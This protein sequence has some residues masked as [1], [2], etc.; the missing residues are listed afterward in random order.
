[1]RQRYQHLLSNFA[2]AVVCS[3]TIT[4]AHDDASH[5]I[6]NAT[7]AALPLTASATTANTVTLTVDIQQRQCRVHTQ[8]AAQPLAASVAD[9]VPC[10]HTITAAHDDASHSIHNATAAALPLTA[11]ATTANTITL[12]GD[13][14]RR[15]C[16]VH[17]QC[18]AQRLASSVADVVRCSHTNGTT[19]SPHSQPPAEPSPSP[20]HLHRISSVTRV[21]LWCSASDRA[22]HPASPKCFVPARGRRPT[23]EEAKPRTGRGTTT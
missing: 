4:A 11:S 12:T 1:M 7:A 9:V 16:R 15:Q 13:I 8:C 18:A 3:H 22:R 14:Q 5:S 17:T 2:D 6:H 20:R 21:V 10:S 19:S 23:M